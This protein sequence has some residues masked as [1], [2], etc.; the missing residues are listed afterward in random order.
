MVTR[1]FLGW[2]PGPETEHPSLPNVRCLNSTARKPWAKLLSP[3]EFGSTLTER[4]AG[5]DAVGLKMLRPA[6]TATNAQPLRLVKQG[7][8]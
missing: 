6:P 8:V 7:S 2:I 1:H 4:G 5:Y 3:D